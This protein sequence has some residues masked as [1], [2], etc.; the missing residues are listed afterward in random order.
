MI[1][2]NANVSSVNMNGAGSISGGQN[3]AQPAGKFAEA[4]KE[5][6]KSISKVDDQQH[7]SD[8]NITDLLAGKDE[9]I[10]SV[11][12]NVAKAD[13]SF[14]LLVGVRNKLVEAYKQTMNM[15]L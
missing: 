14:R 12:A 2:F 6:G 4:I 10:S 15:Q 1:N 13:M 11:V 8:M 5:A 9:D 3:A 7:V